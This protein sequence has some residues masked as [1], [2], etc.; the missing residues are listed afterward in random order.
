MT[1]I[2]E[3]DFQP[4]SMPSTVQKVRAPYMSSIVH[5]KHCP[6][7]GLS[8]VMRVKHD[9]YQS[10]PQLGSFTRNARQRFAIQALPKRGSFTRQTLHMSS[11]AP[12]WGLSNVIRDKHETIQALPQ[13]GPFTCDAR[14]TLYMSSTAPNGVFHMWCVS[15]TAGTHTK[16][17]K[18]N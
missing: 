15:N 12:N 1:F 7:W 6:N 18:V 5:V 4:N 13:L 14:Q 8:H 9:T 16:Q 2:I 11:T 3:R 17:D 10:L